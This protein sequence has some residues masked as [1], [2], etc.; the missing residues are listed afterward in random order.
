MDA[1]KLA[2][3]SGARAAGAAG[4]AGAEV[5]GTGGPFDGNGGGGGP[6]AGG[7]GGGGGALLSIGAA[8]CGRCPD[9][10]G[11]R[12]VPAAGCGRGAE[13]GGGLFTL[14]DGGGGRGAGDGGPPAGC[15]TASAIVFITSAAVS[16]F[17]KSLFFTPACA[18]NFLH[19]TGMSRISNPLFA[20]HPI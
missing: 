14:E 9:G 3:G 2:R 12:G 19:S 17:F 7:I 5:R 20:S 1:R 11:G 18:N 16:A 8:G 4:A 6:P 10:G 13:G 15:V